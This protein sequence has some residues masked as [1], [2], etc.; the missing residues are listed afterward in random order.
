MNADTMSEWFRRQGKRVFHT[1]GSYWVELAPRVYQAFPFH[2]IIKLDNG[3]PITVLRRSGA[4]GI[5]YSTPLDSSE[6]MVSYHVVNSGK[7]YSLDHLSKKARYDVRKGLRVYNVEPISLDRL[8]GEGWELRHETLV[9]Q[10]RVEAESRL[11]WEKLCHSA[12]GLQGVECWGAIE[13]GTGR[14][15]SALFAF[16]CDDCFCILYQQSRTEQMSFGANNV[17]TYV[18]TDEVLKRTEINQVFYGLHSLDAPAGIDDYKF[19]MGFSARPVRQRV[20]FHPWISPLFNRVSYSALRCLLNCK[21]GSNTLAKAEGMIRFS[22]EGKWPLAEQQWPE[23]LAE[24]RP[25]LLR[26]MQYSQTDDSAPE[27][28]AE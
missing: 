13:K 1:A 4:I 21:P 16:I 17:L 12:N 15:A 18:V 2:W 6:G 23:A 7:I 24:Q 10:G 27:S 19:R 14:L 11:W 3:E 9:R 20:V 22:L 25:N 28:D 26:N 8:A 5:R